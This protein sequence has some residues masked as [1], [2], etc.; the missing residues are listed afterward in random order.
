MDNTEESSD[1]VFIIYLGATF[2][3]LI[4]VNNVMSQL[5]VIKGSKMILYN[6]QRLF[7]FNKTDKW[8]L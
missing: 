2:F 7:R 4:D 8:C 3:Q 6:L 1:T 5:V